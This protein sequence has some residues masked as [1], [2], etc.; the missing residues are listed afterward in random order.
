MNETGL[1][2]ITKIVEGHKDTLQIKPQQWPSFKHQ[3][4]VK[5]E[6]VELTLEDKDDGQT[7]ATKLPGRTI[8]LHRGSVHGPASP[9]RGS[10]QTKLLAASTT[11]GNLAAPRGP[12]QPA[13]LKVG[14]YE[15]LKKQYRSEGFRDGI[16][17]GSICMIAAV[18]I[19]VLSSTGLQR[20][21]AC[22]RG[23]L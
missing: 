23:M 17:I 1:I 13:G 9:L 21:G 11:G 22:L 15:R 14:E 3:G 6:R 7:A 8:P 10:V 20:V 5:T 16:I 19:V 12:A 4:W 18:S 2:T